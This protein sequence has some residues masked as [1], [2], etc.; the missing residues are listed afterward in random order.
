[1]QG[2][3][4]RGAGFGGVEGHGEVRVGAQVHAFVGEGETADMAGVGGVAPIAGPMIA[5]AATSMLGLL[6]IAR[7]TTGRV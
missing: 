6:V 7:P 4:G 2:V 1:M 5:G 3:L